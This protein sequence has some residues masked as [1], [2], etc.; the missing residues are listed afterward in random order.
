MIRSSSVDFTAPCRR[1]VRK[2]GK[3]R[4]RLSCY[5]LIALA[6]CG[7]VPVVLR[8]QTKPVSK[9]ADPAFTDQ[10]MQFLARTIVTAAKSASTIDDPKVIDAAAESAKAGITDRILKYY[11]LDK[12]SPQEAKAPGTPDFSR[13]NRDIENTARQGLATS[14]SRPVDWMAELAKSAW[15]GTANPAQILRYAVDQNAEK[16]RTAMAGN[17]QQLKDALSK[18][19]VDLVNTEELKPDKFSVVKKIALPGWLDVTHLQQAADLIGIHSLTQESDK[20][21]TA[22]AKF[23]EAQ[24]AD[25][26]KQQLAM[27]ANDPTKLTPAEVAGRNANQQ[28]IGNETLNKNLPSTLKADP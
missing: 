15:L 13:L 12:S 22:Q 17:P 25:I 11:G 23:L 27:K 21:S 8:G 4:A 1:D 14:V 19:F 28:K 7:T 20:L 16:I 18:T 2:H 6:L 10:V 3:L 9:P 26:I 24:K 5:L